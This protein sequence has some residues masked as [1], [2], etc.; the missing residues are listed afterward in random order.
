MN[1]VHSRDTQEHEDDSFRGAT[2][3]LHC[4]LDGCMGFVGYVCLDIVLH[5]DAAEGYS[6]G[7]NWIVKAAIIYLKLL[8]FHMMVPYF[9]LFILKV[10]PDFTPHYNTMYLIFVGFKKAFDN[11]DSTKYFFK[12]L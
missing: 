5:R 7:E 8:N 11:S 12:S 6:E 2:Q 4:V 10:F 3:H 1:S 9:H